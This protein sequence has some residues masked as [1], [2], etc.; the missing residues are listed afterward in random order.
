MASGA[1]TRSMIGHAT[2]EM[3]L[4]YTHI[5]REE[6][7]GAVDRAFALVDGP[8]SGTSCGMFP[9]RGRC[10]KYQPTRNYP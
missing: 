5:E 4:H 9:N 6:K 1:I 8:K 2:E 7:Q 3:F 10:S